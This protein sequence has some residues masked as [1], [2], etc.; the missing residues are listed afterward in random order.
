[1][2][3]EKYTAKDLVTYNKKCEQTVA[4]SQ[5]YTRIQHGNVSPI[6]HFN[7]E[8]VLDFSHIDITDDT[9]TIEGWKKS[10]DLF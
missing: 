4:R 8:S 7:K 5:A 2:L 6:Y 10:I 9:I 3:E 1:M